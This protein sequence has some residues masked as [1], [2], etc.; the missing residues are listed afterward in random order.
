MIAAGGLSLDDLFARVRL[1]VSEVTNGGEVPW[2]ASQIEG[3][4]LITERSADA[5]PPPN[6]IPLADLRSKPMRSYSGAEDAYAAALALDSMEGYEQ[7]LALYPSGPYS[8]R[9]AAMLAVR[10]EEII[11]R[12]C[13]L[14]VSAPLPEWTACLGRAAAIGDDWRAARSGAQFRILRLRRPAAAAG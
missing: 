10:R 4:F 9:V 1:R 7:F 2:Y 12:R 5:P 6:V 8:R 14:V 3:P 11:W 13:L